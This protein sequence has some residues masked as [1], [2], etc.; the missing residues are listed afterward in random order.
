[1]KSDFSINKITKNQCCEILTKYHYLSKIQKGFKSGFN[2]GLFANGD[3]LVGVVI[4]SAFPVPELAVGLF[5]LSRS[6]QGG[7]FELS[8]L[9]L[10]PEIQIKE[11]NIASWFVSRAIRKLKSE[12]NVRAILSYA[13]N[14]FHSGT[15]Y[16]ASNFNYYGLSEAKKDFFAKMEDG[17]YKKV[18]RGKVSGTIG[19]WRDRS[20]KHRF[21]MVFD[22]ELTPLWKK[23]RWKK[24]NENDP[25][26]E[27]RYPWRD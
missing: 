20:R 5:G 23:E 22:S 6:Q 7:L 26:D 13:D 3:R 12:A 16:A 27:S 25:Q 24:S 21:L 18:S 1:M 8:R 2:Y 19:E 15:V 11:H 10:V 14:D 9:C 4:F 17:S